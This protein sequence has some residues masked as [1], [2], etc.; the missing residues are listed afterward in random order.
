MEVCR[1][2]APQI[3]RSVFGSHVSIFASLM[4][5]K[6]QVEAEV[7]KQLKENNVKPDELLKQKMPKTFSM[8]DT[9][10]YLKKEEMS[11][12]DLGDNKYGGK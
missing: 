5:F 1:F 7:S 3:F 10:S 8:E 4:F 11:K 9:F 2:V 12:K 6:A